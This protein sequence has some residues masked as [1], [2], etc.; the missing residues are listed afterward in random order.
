MLSR[1]KVATDRLTATR[2]FSCLPSCPR[3][4]HDGAQNS[5]QSQGPALGF[6]FRAPIGAESLDPVSAQSGQPGVKTPPADAAMKSA[7]AWLAL[8]DA[9]N[10]G[11]AWAEAH[12]V[13]RGMISREA[14]EFGGL[15]ILLAKDKDGVWRMVRSDRY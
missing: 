13:A 3:I 2:R 1:R 14:G 10:C 6:A 8:L 4:A 15:K 5:L 7:V 9:G 12:T 11:Q